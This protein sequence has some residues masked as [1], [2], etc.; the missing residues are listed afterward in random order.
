MR[1]LPSTVSNGS[2][3]SETPGTSF[4]SC[5]VRNGGKA[6][7]ITRREFSAIA[8]RAAALGAGA[9]FFSFLDE[10]P[11]LAQDVLNSAAVTKIHKHIQ[12]HETEHIARIQQFLRL[13]S[14]SSWGW[15]TPVGGHENMRECADSLIDMF[16][17]MGCQWAELAKT[18]GLP[19]V[20]A[21]YDAGAK[22]TISHYFMYDTQPIYEKPWSSPP[23]A[24]NVVNLPPFGRTIIARGAINSKGPLVAFLNACESII[25]VEGKLPVNILFT[26]D[27]EEEQ[28][29][30]HFHQVLQP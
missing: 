24:A 1:R 30:P 5:R 18:D 8:A 2:C 13:P 20:A 29:S 9:S 10:P 3:I 25:A 4:G 14:V 12:E 19:G 15:G 11:G 27:G 28:A 26:C 21:G 17:K 22:K 6:M 23:L 16:K 7:E